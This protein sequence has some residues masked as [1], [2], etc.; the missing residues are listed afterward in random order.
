MIAMFFHYCVLIYNGLVMPFKESSHYFFQ[1]FNEIFIFWTIC[2]LMTFADLIFD[3]YAN[4]TMG[5]ILITV[6][7]ANLAINFI[8][9]IGSAIKRNFR[10]YRIKYLLWKRNRLRAKIEERHARLLAE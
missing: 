7:S 2:V 4:N 5:W 1:Q 9:I 8:Y 3:D 10:K 6:V